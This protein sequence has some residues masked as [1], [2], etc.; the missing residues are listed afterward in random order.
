MRY[1]FVLFFLV[2]S[3]LWISGCSGNRPK[4]SVETDIDFGDVV[5]GAV[6][7]RDVPVENEGEGPLVI[8]AVSTSCGC[9]TATMEP[10][11]ILPGQSG[12]LHLEFDSGA[13]GPESNGELLRQVFIA[14]NDSSQPEAVIE[15]R[16]NVLPQP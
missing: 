12:I 4:I 3:A 2:V 1:K 13:H 7:I 5:N 15:I 6:I 9:T 16:A 11:T 8:E 10:M 14:S